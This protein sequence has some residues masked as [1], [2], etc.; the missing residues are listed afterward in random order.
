MVDAKYILGREVSN[1][2]IQWNGKFF[3]RPMVE[4]NARKILSGFCE[5]NAQNIEIIMSSQSIPA[6]WAGRNG[7]IV[8]LVEG[9][10]GFCPECHSALKVASGEEW[11]GKHKVKV[12]WLQCFQSAHPSHGY[13]SQSPYRSHRAYIKGEKFPEKTPEVPVVKAEV[14]VKPDEP[15]PVKT[16]IP[17]TDEARHEAFEK[18]F[19]LI[20]DGGVRALLL[21]GPAGSGKTSMCP[22]LADSLSKH[23]GVEFGL[24]I[25]SGNAETEAAQLG[26]FKNPHDGSEKLSA[27]MQAATNSD[28]PHVITIDEADAITPGNMLT[29][30]SPVAQRFVMFDGRKV[31]VHPLTVFIIT[32][33][34]SNG[35][36]RVYTGRF[37][38]DGAT[39]SR[40][41][42]V[43][44]DYSP[45]IDKAVCPDAAIRSEVN[46][47]R[48]RVNDDPTLA[49]NF[50]A[51]VGTRL[52][53]Q[54]TQVGR[55]FGLHGREAV[56]ETLR[57]GNSPD[58]LKSL[59]Y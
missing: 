58:T 37:P 32:A 54:A 3:D 59:G 11:K 39:K 31:P 1:N 56:V 24:S 4:A 29:L 23:H 38:M 18:I 7:E 27:I 5:S 13:G 12:F 57:L 8:P 19:R 48:K 28:K 21:E 55:A 33:N 15:K 53:I 52:L 36:N 10:G 26:V 49:R 30:N 51:L 43:F 17:A 16:E 34:A 45:A 9:R 35:A 42:P 50:G 6:T 25:L 14:E 2:K 22:Q 40:F 41:L 20:V 44:C 47:L 46:S